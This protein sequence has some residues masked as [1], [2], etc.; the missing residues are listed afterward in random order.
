LTVKK[1]FCILIGSMESAKIPFYQPR[2]RQLDFISGLLT[3]VVLVA[4]L[5]SGCSKSGLSVQK[6]TPETALGECVLLI[7]GM[8]RTLRSMDA[9]Q[10]RLVAEGYHT[11]NFGYPST[12]KPIEAIVTDHFPEALEQCQ[13]FEPQAIH[14]VSHSLGGIILRSVFKEQK[15]GNM[16]RV[17][18]LSP[19]SH[20][21]VAADSL[22]KWW[23]Y[24][25]LNGPA[26]QQLTT[27]ENSFPN[28]LGPV[29][30]PVG[31]ITGDRFYFFDFWLSFIIPGPDDGKVSVLNARLDGMKD[32]LIVHETHPFIMD[33]EYVQ[34]ETLYF[35][36]KG[37]FKHQ[38]DPLPP[39]SGF[40]WF[41]FSSE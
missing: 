33:S 28:Q 25:W 19:P 9:M 24:E 34:D 1:L 32:F 11:V 5:L 39:V 29:D 4:A 38:K 26:G 40:D 35:L 21:S 10:A 18:M 31:V 27:D 37:I 30:Y 3:F 8:G 12:S 23:L 14:F 17:V 6:P 15:P 22:K 13:Q 20:G 2:H 16:G 36:K 41:S 7:H